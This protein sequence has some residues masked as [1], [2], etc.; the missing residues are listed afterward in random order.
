[1]GFM[2]KIASKMQKMQE[3]MVA[4]QEKMIEAKGLRDIKVLVE[5]TK[6]LRGNLSAEAEISGFVT[7][8]NERQNAWDLKEIYVRISEWWIES[9][10]WTREEAA[11]DHDVQWNATKDIH[12]EGNEGWD[13]VNR[14]KAAAIER[15]V[16][17]KMRG[18]PQEKKKQI[19]GAQQHLVKAAAGGQG[20]VLPP[21]QHKR[22]EF[23]IKMPRTWSPREKDWRLE[24][25]AIA[26]V[27]LQHTWNSESLV[28]PVEHSKRQPSWYFEPLAVPGG[29]KGA[30]GGRGAD[31]FE[32][33]SSIGTFEVIPKGQKATLQI[34]KGGA[35]E[36]LIEFQTP[37][38][39]RKASEFHQKVDPAI[40]QRLMGKL[41]AVSQALNTLRNIAADDPAREKMTKAHQ[42][43]KQF[44]HA[45]YLQMIPSPVQEALKDTKIA[46]EFGLD[47]S[48]VGYPWELLNDGENFLC[49]KQPL[50][51]YVATGSATHSMSFVQRAKQNGVKFLLIVDPDGSLPGAKAEGAAI[52][53]ALSKIEG[54]KI[55]VM[56]GADADSINLITELAEGYD[57]IHYS[58]HAVFDAEH[59]ENS[60]MLLN[61]GLFK[62]F[63]LAGAVKAHPPI[64]AFINACESGKQAD[65]SK[66][67]TK[68][69]N[70]VAGLAS[71]FLVNGIN[72][73]GPMWPVFD[74]AA[75]SFA[76][77]FYFAVLS[78]TPLGEAMMKAKKFIFDLFKGEEIAWA[79][80]S[81]YGDPTQTLEI[82]KAG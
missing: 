13:S 71:A 42:A 50:G 27:D 15:A 18:P 6:S 31:F 28:I 23:T 65:W 78:G 20:L 62:A 38:V 73:I 52:Q 8:S 39:V 53:E 74:D 55:K 29:A 49:L 44:G 57:F 22:F 45:L 24:L 75:L 40:L 82:Q 58:G 34:A 2:D 16:Q 54:V 35:D 76:K 64:L 36:F 61:D 43:L 69:E 17:E 46:M 79:S 7:V 70:N 5:V 30:A 32:R 21:G 67:E 3:N 66:G 19:V 77:N 9:K 41:D 72:F 10:P 81:L 1:M 12:P 60:G 14:R 11:N 4:K 63:S 26:K 56:T 80:Y 68:Y 51:R 25:D 37:G 59:P 47:E 33:P 48:L